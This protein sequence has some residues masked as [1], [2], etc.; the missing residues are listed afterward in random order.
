MFFCAFGLPYLDIRF[1]QDSALNSLYYAALAL[2][3]YSACF[4]AET[5]RS[6]VAAIPLGQTEAARAIGL[7][8]GQ[9][10]QLVV[11]PLAFRAV[12]PPLGSV[13][14]ATLKNCAIA[15]AFN[16]QELISAMR[17]AIEL[18]GDLLVPILVGTAV[19][20]LLLALILGRIFA[21]LERKVQ[22]R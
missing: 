2:A 8:F 15:S 11:L 21:A 4:V 19:V 18:R 16:N 22:V 6:G 10:L 9:N 1:A 3:L 17:T 13:V 20:Y 7:G 12:I 5:L 14:I